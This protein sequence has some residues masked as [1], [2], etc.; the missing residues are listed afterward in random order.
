ME[1]PDDGGHRDGDGRGGSD[2]HV[3]RRSAQADERN[4][5]AIQRHVAGQR[6]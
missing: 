4:T 2:G 3:R 6:G 5:P 1:E